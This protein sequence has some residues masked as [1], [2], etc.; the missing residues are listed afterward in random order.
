MVF[1]VGKV[2]DNL[3]IV[4]Y[5]YDRF[6]LNILLILNKNMYFFINCRKIV[7]NIIIREYTGFITYFFKIFMAENN[8]TKII[9]CT[10][11]TK[12]CQNRDGEKLDDLI[13]KTKEEGF[14]PVFPCSFLKSYFVK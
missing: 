7:D 12:F 13:K 1:F 4:N 2:V 6:L 5:I 9:T 8:K 10:I 11:C 14:K 3:N